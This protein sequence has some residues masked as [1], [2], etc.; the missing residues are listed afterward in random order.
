MCAERLAWAKRP[1]AV[2]ASR[3][4]T[5]QA[6]AAATQPHRRERIARRSGAG[7]IARSLDAPAIPAVTDCLPD[8]WDRSR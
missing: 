5:D 7:I 1:K 8:G 6:G 4:T 3:Q 2:N